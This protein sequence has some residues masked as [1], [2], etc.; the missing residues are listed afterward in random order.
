MPFYGLQGGGVLL[1]GGIQG[2]QRFLPGV[3]KFESCIIRDNTAVT[4]V[5]LHLELSLNFF[6]HPLALNL[7]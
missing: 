6:R 7:Y 4:S 5:C 2:V 1:N 3:A